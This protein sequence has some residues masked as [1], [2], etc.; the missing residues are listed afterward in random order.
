MRQIYPFLSFFA[1]AVF[2]TLYINKMFGFEA[3]VLHKYN[4]EVMK[5]FREVFNTLPLAAVIEQKVIVLHGGLFEE[6]NV[7]IRDIN[8]LDRFNNGSSHLMEE[9]LWSDPADI[10]GT[11]P[12][13]RGA[14]VQ[15]GSDVTKAFLDYNN[16]SLLVRSHEMKDNGYEITHDNRCVTL[17]SAA[18]YCDQCGNK[19]AIMKLGRDLIPRYDTVYQTRAFS[20]V[21]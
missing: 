1:I 21:V 12:S 14:G 20:S 11:Q 2:L 16:L 15:F 5:L 10:R 19:G 18:N 7:S 8:K 17:F 3:E 4:A 9:I 6:P 13:R